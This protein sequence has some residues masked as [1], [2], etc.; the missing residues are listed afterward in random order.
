MSLSSNISEK[1]A[2]IWH[3]DI[4]INQGFVRFHQEKPLQFYTK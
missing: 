2:L 4:E 1:A 3:H